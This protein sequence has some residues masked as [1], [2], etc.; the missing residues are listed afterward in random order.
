M[1]DSPW[2]R[3]CQCVLIRGRVGR[4]GAARREFFLI[5]PGIGRPSLAPIGDRCSSVSGRQKSAFQKNS[6]SIDKNGRVGSPP[7]RF[8]EAATS[9]PPIPGFAAIGEVDRFG[10]VGNVF[11][12]KLNR[13][14]DR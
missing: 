5:A 1:A 9:A 8:E 14:D 13:S 2:R 7:V 10:L 4:L 3:R 6:A 11:R 12:G